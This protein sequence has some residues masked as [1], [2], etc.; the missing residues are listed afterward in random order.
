MLSLTWHGIFKEVEKSRHDSVM[1]TLR[2]SLFIIIVT[3]CCATS[4]AQS[5]LIV[6]IK[7]SYRSVIRN[8]ETLHRWLNANASGRAGMEMSVQSLVKHANENE[9]LSDLFL[10]E[11]RLSAQEAIRRYGILD[12]FEYAEPDYI[13]SAA[14]MK[15]VAEPPDDPGFSLQWY[16]RN[17]GTFNYAGNT[18][19]EGADIQ[20]LDA[21]ELTQGDSSIIVAILDSGIN[22]DHTEFKGRLW[23]NA[24]EVAGDDKDNDRNGFTDD[25]HGWDFVNNDNDPRDDSGHGT[26][27][28]GILAANANNG[29]GFAGIDQ[30]CKLMICKVLDQDLTGYYSQWIA[31]LYYAIDHGARIVNFSLGGEE[32]SQA[33]KGAIEYAESKGVL[34]VA[35]M[36]NFNTSRPYYPAAYAQTLSVGATDPDDARSVAFNN[37]PLYGSNY[38]SHLDVVAPGNYIYGLNKTSSGNGTVWSGTSMAAPIVSGIASLLLA[39]DPGR[40]AEEVK[41]ILYAATEDQV[42]DPEE[43]Q[44]GWDI[45]YG[46]GRVNAFAAVTNANPQPAEEKLLAYPNPAQTNVTLYLRQMISSPLRI[47]LTDTEGR[48]VGSFYESAQEGRIFQQDFRVDHFAAGA[49]IVKVSTSNSIHYGRL[50][51]IR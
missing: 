8:T 40:T 27:V 38:G 2:N 46:Y 7:S 5:R 37:N 45:F 14:G 35:A 29:F 32:P 25:Y 39:Q 15:I 51:I 18:A 24:A 49:Y 16:L 20:L 6:K 3:F 12:I 48:E 19:I 36:Q 1:A 47:V 22:P 17:D 21:W 9:S 13:G 10:I 43:D 30:Q 26:A 42:G 34:L 44:K 50:M 41:A 11:S 23:G 28:A 31:G 33:L 4:I